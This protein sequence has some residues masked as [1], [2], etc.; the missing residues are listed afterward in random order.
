MKRLVA[1]AIVLGAGMLAYAAVGNGSVVA[2]APVT[3]VQ[4]NGGSGSGS[5]IISNVSSGGYT[6]DVASDVACDPAVGF[7]IAGGTPFSLPGMAQKSVGYTCAP[8]QPAGLQRCLLH[9]TDTNTGDP[10]VDLLAVCEN[11]PSSTL[12]PSSTLLDFSTVSIGDTGT[13]ALGITNPSSTTITKLFLQTDDLDGDFEISIPCNP[14]AAYCDGVI[15]PINLGQSATVFVKCSPR[16]AGLHT[17]Q[18]EVATDTAQ[19]FDQPVMLSCNGSAATIP[20]LGVSPDTVDI[21]TPVEVVSTTAQTT[22][23]V[24]NLGADTLQVTDIRTVDVDTGAAV[25][26][27]FALSGTCT[28]TPCSLTNAQLVNVNLTFDP[29]AI[30]TRHASLLISF[31]DTID[32]TRSIPLVGVGQGATLDLV[33]NAATLDF[34]TVPVGHSSMLAFGLANRGNRDTAAALATTPAGAPFTLN[35][36]TMTTVSP[37]VVKSVMVT[38]TPAMAGSATTSISAQS[39]DTDGSLPIAITATCNGTIAPLFANPTALTLGEIR[40]GSGPQA[41]PI[42]IESTGAQLTIAGV[43]A[44]DIANPNV[45]VGSASSPTT[46]SEVTVTIDPQTEGDLKTDLVVAD[47][48]GDSV[49]IPIVTRIVTPSYTVPPALDVGTF[50]V[51]QPTASSN[52][53][54]SSNGTATLALGEPT[55]SSA[56]PF[57]LSFTSPSVYPAILPAGQTA[58]LA[59]T[60]ERQ[61]VPT[62]LT[63]TLTWTTDVDSAL[64]STT[65]ITASFITTGGAI[66]PPI[67]DFGKEPVHLVVDDAQ[68]VM[69]QN[70]NGS[71][72]ELDPPT[73]KSP[74]SIDSPNFPATLDP[75]ETA[76]FSVGFHPTKINT[77]D[78]PL[79]FTDTLTISSPQLMGAPLQVQLVGTSITDGSSGV[80]AGTGSGA[81]QDTSF[82]ACSCNSNAPGGGLPI[83]LALA[84]VIVRRRS[85]SS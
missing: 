34:G 81:I 61:A 41:F 48:G 2:I 56:S 30:G 11:A 55:V 1:I 35:P 8:G 27:T 43:P 33:A 14:D 54:L 67:L 21:A 59:V 39:S 80:D 32:R 36:A 74:F 73:I 75:N 72:L 58:T 15:Q 24:E 37:G 18:L 52:V 23:H 63:D 83:V 12:V 71:V 78:A 49:K 51:G 10:L 7:A 31:H 40:I 47:T 9:A 64:T 50:C 29:S 53:A 77:N 65:A 82:Y 79:T 60:P 76:T 44:L 57:L 5:A 69:I 84:L 42:Q 70:C 66:G 22:V 26:W 17:A 28:G 68:R 20:V 85:G 25:D 6:V 3:I 4:T 46:T 19:R 38:C 13:I 45:A 16:S 62:T